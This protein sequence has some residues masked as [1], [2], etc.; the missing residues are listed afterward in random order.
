MGLPTG[1]TEP[2]SAHAASGPAS[3]SREGVERR[4][5][6]AIRWAL[7]GNAVAVP[8]ARWLGAR[9]ARPYDHKHV[10]LV[11][12]PAGGDDSGGGGGGWR[13]GGECASAARPFPSAVPPAWPRAAWGGFP[14][15]PADSDASGSGSHPPHCGRYACPGLGEA[16]VYTPF[17]PLGPFISSASPSPGP[18]PSAEATAV[19][20]QRMRVRGWAL[21]G[22]LKA[23]VD[24][25]V[26]SAAPGGRRHPAPSAGAVSGAA[27]GATSNVPTPADAVGAAAASM[28]ARCGACRPCRSSP[29]LLPSSS[30]PHPLPPSKGC[31]L[32]G[33]RRLAAAGH[34][35]AALTCLGAAAVGARVA[36]F[37]PL[38]ARFYSG[39]LTSW[40]AG[41]CAH[42][43]LYDDDAAE[44]VQ[45][46]KQTVEL[47]EMPHPQ[48]PPSHP[49]PQ[50]QPQLQL[51]GG[52][53]ALDP[54]EM[55]SARAGEE[56]PPTSPRERGATACD[57]EAPP[58]PHAAACLVRTPRHDPRAPPLASPPPPPPP[59]PLF[60][61][62]Q[63]RPPP[64]PPPP[65]AP[66]PRARAPPPR[67]TDGSFAVGDAATAE[68]ADGAWRS[69][70]MPSVPAGLS[71]YPAHHLLRANHR[72][73]TQ[74][75]KR[76]RA[77]LLQQSFAAA[78]AE[79]VEEA[80][81]AEA[82][83]VRR[84]A[85]ALR[86]AAPASAA[87]RGDESNSDAFDADACF[88][89]AFDGEVGVAP[90]RRTPLGGRCRVCTSQKRGGCGTEASPRSCLNRMPDMPFA[91]PRPR[92][93]PAHAATAAAASKSAR[94][95]RAARSQP[96][97][98][99][100]G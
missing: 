81:G 74:P 48:P 84:E 14:P 7:I 42:R 30:P 3:S 64:P 46:W 32:V 58:D 82:A 37:W 22:P 73:E 10:P 23:A 41:G 19:W 57:D 6:V 36:V 55:A 9:L 86:A 31:L 33:A 80:A 8:V 52:D 45:L 85:A 62:P 34:G 59:P 20:A 12:S 51:Q 53:P 38:D 25:I 43:V 60:L 71:S 26:A 98:F 29:T 66:A 72:G 76:R 54:H 89:E 39:T 77:E 67:F 70:A 97:N 50:P 65:R 1:W 47:R 40:N 100:L 87:P 15:T 75:P 49:Q 91:P 92:V 95:G 28:A 96:L 99:A 88:Q 78:A 93:P 16:P 79:A 24:A 13:G 83:R 27:A 56:E 17:V 61:Q 4:F 35:G 44:T 90:P 11:S 2:A 69:M 21:A 5:E 68:D 63:R 18:P 94:G